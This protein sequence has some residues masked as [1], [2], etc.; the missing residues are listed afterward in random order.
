MKNELPSA[1]EMLGILK[2]YLEEPLSINAV[3]PSAGIQESRPRASEETDSEALTLL[4]ARLR[5][6]RDQWMQDAADIAVDGDFCCGLTRQHDADALSAL[7]VD[8]LPRQIVKENDTR[9]PAGHQG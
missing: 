1:A 9:P 2:P 8:P 6:L 7:L 5:D 4:R 3:D